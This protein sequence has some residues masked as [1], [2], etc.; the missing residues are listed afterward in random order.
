[1]MFRIESRQS[2][3]HHSQLLVMFLLLLQAVLN[4]VVF[5]F[6]LAERHLVAVPQ[7]RT[8]SSSEGVHFL[9]FPDEGAFVFEPDLVLL[10]E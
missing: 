9:W 10:Y 1:M 3:L 4:V 7:S 5:D 2:H 8:R 6:V